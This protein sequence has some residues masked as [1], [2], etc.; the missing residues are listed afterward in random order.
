MKIGD[1]ILQPQRYK[2]FVPS[3]FP[4]AESVEL[5]TT[6]HNLH[7]EAALVLGKL[8]GITQLLPDL[9]FFI[10]MYV[11]KEA[12]L[13]AQ[14][15]GTRA[16]MID[17]IRAE[18]ELT[19]DLPKDVN[20][21]LRYIE[22]MNYGLK[23][24]EELP[25][26]L[27]LIREVHRVLLTRARSDHYAAPGEFRASQNWIG[28]ASPVTARFVPP[29]VQ[30]MHRALDDFEKFLHAK[31]VLPPLIKSA[32]AHA[33]FETIHPFLDGNGR[34]GRLLIT[35]FLCQQ[36]ILERPVLYLSEYFKKHREVYFDLLQDYHDKGQ[37]SPWIAFF[38]EGVAT[39]SKEAIDTSR[40]ITKLREE[41]TARVQALGR[42]AELG[43]KV[44]RELYRLPIVDVKK[45]QEWTGLTRPSANNLVKRL[46]DIGILEQRDKAKAYRRQFEY[47]R[48]LFL[49]THE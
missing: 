17:A 16:T 42:R 46:V 39:I 28:G 2:A 45:V 10:F 41:D 30:E 40:Q 20:D 38:L 49:F 11:R 5:D 6:I 13:S 3:G 8:D 19:R 33:Q 31:N 9:G 24:L 15:E 47:R 21:I 26:S 43:T 4:P 44:L 48:Y 12:A 36:K 18:T 22:A 1:F 29:P 25:L 27:R 35:F 34:V 32:L 7:A 37:V 23:R 14:I